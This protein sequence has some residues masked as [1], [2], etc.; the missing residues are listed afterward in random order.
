M[1]ITLSRHWLAIASLSVTAMTAPM[2]TTLYAV[3]EPP[4]KFISED[5]LDKMRRWEEKI[6]DAFRDSLENEPGNPGAGFNASIEVREQTDRYTVR[7]ALPE[8]DLDRI[9]VSMS[10]TTLRI[11]GKEGYEQT[12]VLR[13]AIPGAPPELERQRGKMV[14]TV[15]KHNSAI[16]AVPPMPP[17]QEP[18]MSPDRWDDAFNRVEKI[19]REMD[20][21]FGDFFKDIPAFGIDPSNPA[22]PDLDS[23]LDLIGSGN[24]Y[25][26]RAYFPGRD[27]SNVNVTVEGL[28]LTVET[29]ADLR[30]KDDGRHGIGDSMRMSNDSQVLTLPGP[31]KAHEMK[32][33]RKEGILIVT[34]P[35]A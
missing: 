4:P 6:S 1:K 30:S 7:L 32:I 26:V 16:T 17:P 28:T 5:F 20:R 15:R 14:I 27:L 2:G 19:A 3:D 25:I 22:V 33:E 24:N 29:K 13:N 9:T 11:G 31:V 12:V 34:L 23:N 10:G 35:K 8:A 18:L 21:V